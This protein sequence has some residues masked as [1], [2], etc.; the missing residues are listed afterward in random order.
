MRNKAFSDIRLTIERDRTFSAGKKCGV[1]SV[2]KLYHLRL[3]RQHVAS[4][5][6]RGKKCSMQ[7]LGLKMREV[8]LRK[9]VRKEKEISLN[10]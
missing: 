4:T 7:F 5:S 3:K 10:F 6:R 1:K 8:Y 9:K 2:A